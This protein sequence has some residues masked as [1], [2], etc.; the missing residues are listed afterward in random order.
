[1]LKLGLIFGDKFRV[2]PVLFVGL[3]ELFQRVNQGF[4]DKYAA[5]GAKMAAIIR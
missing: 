3:V 4:G 2:A 5:V 1:M